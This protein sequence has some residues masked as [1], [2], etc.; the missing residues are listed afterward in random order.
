M[1]VVDF[2]SRKVVPDRALVVDALLVG[3]FAVFVAFVID[4]FGFNF[5]IDFLPD[6]FELLSIVAI[7]VYL[8]S[9]FNIKIFK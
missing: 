1:A 8:K 4:F 3:L 5:L 9:L 6:G 2:N 7:S